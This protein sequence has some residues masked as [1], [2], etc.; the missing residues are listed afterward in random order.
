MLQFGRWDFFAKQKFL[1]VF[2]TASGPFCISICSWK[3]W[4][5]FVISG[6]RSIL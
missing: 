1:L 4:S 3:R 2:V 5:V 6:F